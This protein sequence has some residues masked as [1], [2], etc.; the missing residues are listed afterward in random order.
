MR[1][2]VTGCAPSCMCTYPDGLRRKKAGLRGAVG[3]TA[4]P[5][6]RLYGCGATSL[7]VETLSSV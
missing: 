1:M 5:F 7:H 6:W 4:G 3:V 2:F